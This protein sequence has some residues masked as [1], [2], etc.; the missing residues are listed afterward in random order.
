[1][2]IIND[3][4]NRDERALDGPDRID[5]H[6]PVNHHRSSGK[7]PYLHVGV[8]LAWIKGRVSLGEVMT[9]WHE[10]ETD[11]ERART[12]GTS[13]DRGRAALPARLG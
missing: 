8:T 5:L 2:L 6:R 3:T 7:G 11:N 13:S 9:H 12:A 1:M 10:W 4:A